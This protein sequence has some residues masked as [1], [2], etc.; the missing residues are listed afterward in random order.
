M[1]DPREIDER[2]TELERIVE[3]DAA[4]RRLEQSA[5]GPGNLRVY[6]GGSIRIED[7]GD[8]EIV[9][10]DLILGEGIIDGNALKDQFSVD[11][12]TGSATEFAVGGTWTDIVTLSYQPPA[13]ASNVIVIA[14]STGIANDM[15]SDEFSQR[16]LSRFVMAGATSPEAAGRSF[17]YILMRT[18]A[19]LTNAWAAIRPAE[20]QMPV[21]FQVR[22]DGGG[23][24]ETIDNRVGVQATFIAMS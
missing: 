3:M 7:G 4:V 19:N 11:H 6:D 15:R 23:T 17:I 16:I 18:A 5:I 24:A 21:T 20:T 8:L 2:L 22:G 10:G 9:H 12:R 13:W 1:I 14:R